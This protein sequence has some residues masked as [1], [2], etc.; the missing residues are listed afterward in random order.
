[1]RDLL[2]QRKSKD[3]TFSRVSEAG[4]KVV[5]FSKW[6]EGSEVDIVISLLVRSSSSHNSP[7]CTT[8]M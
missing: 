8:P 6:L 3:Q 2:C 7:Y 1:M 5:W 4:G